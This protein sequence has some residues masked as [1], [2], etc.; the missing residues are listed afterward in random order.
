MKRP[1]PNYTVLSGV[2]QGSILG[3]MLYS[4]YT[5]DLPITGHTLLATYADDTTILASHEN[6]I[7]ASRI[8]QMSLDQLEEW[9]KRWRIKANETTSVHITFALRPG[10]CPPVLLNGTRIP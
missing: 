6:P 5:A 8:L 4:I 10:T 2:L 7:E 9:L 1:I 3:P